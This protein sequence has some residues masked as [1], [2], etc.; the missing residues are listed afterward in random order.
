MNAIKKARPSGLVY[1]KVS[2]MAPLKWLSANA[3]A[4]MLGPMVS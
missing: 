1:A 4:M 2:K 3:M